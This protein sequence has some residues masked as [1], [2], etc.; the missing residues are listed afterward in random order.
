MEI[1]VNFWSRR[2]P[3]RLVIRMAK[4]SPPGQWLKLSSDSQASLREPSASKT[5]I[6]SSGVPARNTTVSLSDTG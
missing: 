4:S 2:R 5:A 3:T 1:P 6:S